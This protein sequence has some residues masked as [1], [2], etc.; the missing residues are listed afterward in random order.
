MASNSSE[1]SS[2][3]AGQIRIA[4]RQS[5]RRSAPRPDTLANVFA[6]ADDLSVSGGHVL[7]I[8]RQGVTPAFWLDSSDGESRR[9]RFSFMGTGT[10]IPDVPVFDYLKNELRDRYCARP[11]IAFRFQWRIRRVLR[12]RIEI[13]MR[14]S[15]GAPIA[16]SGFPP[17]FRRS[18]PCLRSSGAMPLSGLCGHDIRSRRGSSMA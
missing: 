16:L 10:L 7:R 9:S 17:D 14:G 12:L 2:K 6:P 11:R 4:S 1:I 18:L 3:R 5:S 13:G 8:V 15:R